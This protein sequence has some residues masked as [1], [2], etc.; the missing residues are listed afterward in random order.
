VITRRDIWSENICSLGFGDIREGASLKRAI[1]R[2]L[3]CIYNNDNTVFEVT[4]F[5][6][7]LYDPKSPNINLLI[8]S[9]V[10]T[11]VKIM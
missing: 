11:P 3:Q 6:D 4:V 1:V 9:Y 8:S 7:C 5:V 2:M 10:Y